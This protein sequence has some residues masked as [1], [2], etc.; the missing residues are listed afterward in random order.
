M[1]LEDQS[2]LGK[3]WAFPVQFNTQIK[4]VEMAYE[5]EDIRQSLN[6]ILMTKMGERVMRPNFGSQL[7]DS[8]FGSIDSITINRIEDQVK[9]AILEWEPRV[10]LNQVIVDISQMYD[11]RLDLKIDY[12]I[13]LINVRTNIV[14]PYYFKE[15]TNIRQEF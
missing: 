15:G 8:V 10:T 4:S 11:G 5:E 2:F 14:F 13:R 6:I 3:G 12:T 7:S 9:Q 1:S